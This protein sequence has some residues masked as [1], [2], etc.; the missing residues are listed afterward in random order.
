MLARDGGAVWFSDEAVMV[1]DSTDKPLFLQ[2][3][4]TDITE[5]KHA[6]EDMQKAKEKTEAAMRAKSEFLANMSHE[7]RTP[8]NAIIG[9]T[10]LLLD[11]PLNTDQLD[12]V[13]TVRNS[14]EV[15]MSIINNILDFSKIEDGKRE[16]EHQPFDLRSC[17]ESSIDLLAS[18][19]AEKGLTITYIVDD[20]VPENLLGDITSLRQVLVN[21]LGNAIKFT[22]SGEISISVTGQQQDHRLKLN[23]SVRDTGIGIHEDRT[24]RL[25]QPFS[26][27]DMST[28]RK[29]GGTGLGLVISKKL[30]EL[31]GGAIWVDSEPSK[32]STFFFS[33]LADPAP[34]AGPVKARELPIQPTFRTFSSSRNN[35]RILDLIA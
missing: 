21:L 32:G 2:G 14:G 18:K 11:T 6:E 28:T 17:V 13:E 30:V 29:Y 16:L 19:A 5:R 8:L 20:N 15:L 7:I 27:V 31:M 23:F 10:G 26:Q 22:Y 3:V 33:I 24:A 25:F 12:L 4:I 9:M 35:F 34:I 1:Q